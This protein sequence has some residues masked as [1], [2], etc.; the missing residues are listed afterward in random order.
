MA[1]LDLLNNVTAVDRIT[2][3]KAKAD[4]NTAAETAG[5]TTAGPSQPPAGAPEPGQPGQD[6]CIQDNGGLR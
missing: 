4:A 6:D 3:A 5:E 2:S 1:Y